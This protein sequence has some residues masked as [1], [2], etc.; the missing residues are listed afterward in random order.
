[1]TPLNALLHRARTCPDGT[2]FI[3]N[4]VVWTCRDLLEAVERLSR[5]LL[6][7]G[8]RP[9]DRVVLHMPNRPEMAVALYA[10]FRLGAIACPTNTRLK[11]AELRALFQRLQP[12]LYLGE[13]QV[14]A[15]I[16]T[17]EPHILAPER[18]FVIA[19]ND[20]CNHAMPWSA[21]F[22]G[23]GAPPM[24]PEPAD[25]A[26][27]VLLA[28]SGTTGQPKFV[29]H[30][31]A[32][33]AASVAVLP[34]IDLDAAQTVLVMCPMVHASGLFTVLGGMG[35]GAPMVLVERFDPDVVL[36]RIEAHA[37]TW[38]LGVPFMYDALLDRQRQ[39]KRA[40]DSLLHCRSA[41]D[42][43]P[44]QLQSDFETVFGVKLGNIWGASEVIGAH[45][46]ASQPGPVSRTVPGAECRVV[47]DSG[48]D[49]P[50]GEVGEFLIRGPYVTV[51][52]W[53]GPDR[54]EPAT[55]DG[56]YHSGDLMRQCEADELWFVGRKKDVIVR[57]GS[58][59]SP[60]EVEWALASHPLV[61]DAA[62]FGLP[63]DVLGQRVAA[64]V[65]LSDGAGEGAVSAILRDTRRALADYKV[66]ERLLVV[67]AVP[68][69]PIGKIDRRAAAAAMID[70]AA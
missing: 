37:C 41:G 2:A 9:G 65:Q 49:V 62:V 53:A 43:C 19:E 67:D 28:T 14:Y 6:A 31:A 42:V 63:D 24:P 35:F 29:T 55:R 36:D 69:N 47:D 60:V 44:E 40:V 70:R 10:C 1:M 64:V 56:W 57:G 13:Q 16:E 54:I 27:A 21:L 38:I 48:R 3:F 61:H 59:V 26:P 68:R 30:T 52:Y 5:A 58:N 66:P 34:H 11:A 7:R 46:P 50:R 4:D 33:M 51:G 15:N 17:I 8:V 23:A 39:R 32:T 18:R 25:D 45:C 20:A 22:A 12:A